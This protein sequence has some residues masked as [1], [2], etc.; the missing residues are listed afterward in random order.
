MEENYF[1]SMPCMKLF[2]LKGKKVIRRSKK[3]QTIYYYSS[4]TD[5]KENKIML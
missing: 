4:T 2:A 1:W 3:N 5:D